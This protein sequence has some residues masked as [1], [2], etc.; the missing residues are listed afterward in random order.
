M[1][2]PQSRNLTIYNCV[3][4][5]ERLLTTSKA[6]MNKEIIGLIQQIILGPENDHGESTRFKS[7]AARRKGLHG[8]EPALVIVKSPTLRDAGTL[9]GPCQLVH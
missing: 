1:T 5:R 8:T 4:H 7:E 2:S 3:Q 6:K 9:Q